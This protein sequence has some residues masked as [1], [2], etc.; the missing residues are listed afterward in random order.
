VHYKHK[1]GVPNEKGIK[2]NGPETTTFQELLPGR[3]DVYF[4]V[5]EE[6][7]KFEVRYKSKIQSNN[8][9]MQYNG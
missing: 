1:T 2:M 5:Y 7:E 3:Y 8:L 9:K 4:N 6:K